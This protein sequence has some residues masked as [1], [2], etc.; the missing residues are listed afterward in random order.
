MICTHLK[1]PRI[2]LP[3]RSNGN[4]FPGETAI[5]LRTLLKCQRF[6]MTTLPHA[7]APS[8]SDVSLY[9][10]V[11][12]RF[13]IIYTLI[14]RIGKNSAWKF[15]PIFLN[16]LHHGIQSSTIGSTI[17]DFSRLNL[18]AVFQAP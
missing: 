10:F 4:D 8:H 17:V 3:L 12:D 15:T 2:L 16:L 7:F 1:P 13:Q 9:F 11:L 6:Q 14:P 18:F 5:T